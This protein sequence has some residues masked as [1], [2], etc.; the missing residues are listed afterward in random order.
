[1]RVIIA[2]MGVQGRKRKEICGSDFVGYVDPH[3]VGADYKT[4]Q[5]VPL[6]NYDAVLACI[7]DQPKTEMLGY[8]LKNGKHV[9]VEKPLWLNEPALFQKLT[10]LVH[11]NK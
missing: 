2:G 8:C 6:T 10:V 1:M 7:P 5:D 4:I 11:D 3:V 9:L